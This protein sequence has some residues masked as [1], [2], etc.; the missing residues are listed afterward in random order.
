ML[1]RSRVARTFRRKG[2]DLGSSKGGLVVLANGWDGNVEG[3]LERVEMIG[4][5]VRL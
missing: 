4:W 2:V 3:G 5:D 1:G